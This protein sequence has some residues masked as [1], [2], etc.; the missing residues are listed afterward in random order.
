M[1]I[2]SEYALKRPFPRNM[3]E[4]LCEQTEVIYMAKQAGINPLKPHLSCS[5]EIYLDFFVRI[6]K[7]HLALALLP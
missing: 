5:D 2:L 1:D 4:V 6:G 3:S 7:P